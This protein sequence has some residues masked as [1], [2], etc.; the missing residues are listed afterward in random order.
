MAYTVTYKRRTKTGK[1]ST[2]KRRVAGNRPT[3]SPG[4]TSA[5]RRTTTTTTP[6]K[7]VIKAYIPISK[8]G[9]AKTPK[10][11]SYNASF[12]SAADA[13][14]GKQLGISAKSLATGRKS[15][16]IRDPQRSLRGQLQSKSDSARYT[17]KRKA[18]SAKNAV[19][20]DRASYDKKV[21]M[22]RKSLSLTDYTM[23]KTVSKTPRGYKDFYHASET[24]GGT[25]IVRVKKSALAKNPYYKQ[26]KARD[27]F[28]AKLDRAVGR[29]VR[30]AAL[31]VARAGQTVEK[32]FVKGVQ[33]GALRLDRISRSAGKKYRKVVGSLHEVGDTRTVVRSKTTGVKI[34]GPKFGT[35]KTKNYGTGVI[36][37]PKGFGVSP[38]KR[39]K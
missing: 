9:P 7:R 23:P 27:R 16:V 24:S 25:D 2:V 19:A 22:I 10:K 13:K 20:F 4:T 35:G 31:G 1:M 11:K 37:G 38:K 21:T 3:P 18:T 6:A 8:A 5:K 14:L 36:T 15:G 39:K 30:S 17:V 26:M 29:R 28:D 33:S 12:R 34:T 32:T